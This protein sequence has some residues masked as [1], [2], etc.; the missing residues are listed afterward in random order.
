ME[1][2]QALK[3]WSHNST[4][5][6]TEQLSDGFHPLEDNFSDFCKTLETVS[7]TGREPSTQCSICQYYDLLYYGFVTLLRPK[8][9]KSKVACVFYLQKRKWFVRLS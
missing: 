4:L 1:A 2:L 3:L 5:N 8:R 7:N 6:F 9:R